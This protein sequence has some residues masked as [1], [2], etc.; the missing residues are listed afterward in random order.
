MQ[1]D[2]GYRDTCLIFDAKRVK[3]GEFTICSTVLSLSTVRKH[4]DSL[5]SG[6]RV[7]SFFLEVLSRV[8]D[9]V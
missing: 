6:E 9:S 5:V 4:M 3:A 1:G 8:L 2:T 7:A